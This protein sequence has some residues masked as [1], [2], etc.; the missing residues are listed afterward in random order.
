MTMIDEEENM[1]LGGEMT[2]LSSKG[3]TWEAV[4]RRRDNKE[5]RQQLEARRRRE[6][7]VTPGWTTRRGA[8]TGGSTTM[9]GGVDWRLVW[10]WVI[11]R[12]HCGCGGWSAALW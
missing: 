7:A 3:R 5:G 8:A 4:T 9:K 11:G 10:T 12:C 1:L 6:D 2:M